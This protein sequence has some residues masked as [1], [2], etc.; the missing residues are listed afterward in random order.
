MHG[1]HDFAHVPWLR[2]LF[3][4]LQAIDVNL[5]TRCKLLK[6]ARNGDV[7]VFERGPWDTLADVMLDVGDANLPDSCWGRWITRS[8]R[9]RGPVFWIARDREQ[10]LSCRPE[11]EFDGNL[12]RK[13]QIYREL[14]RLP[15]W[16]VIDNN[17]PLPVVLR[18]I[19]Q[20]LADYVNRLEAKRDLG[21]P[22]N[23]V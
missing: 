5:A 6:A 8:V 23:R 16:Q 22:D 13:I 12:D 9:R 11:L 10:I 2:W 18:E 19:D 17:R 15:D 21:T 20:R 1:Y 14:S 3:P 4:K 7:I